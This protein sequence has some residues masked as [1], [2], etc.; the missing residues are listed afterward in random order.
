MYTSISDFIKDWEY[1]SEATLKMLNNITD[2]SLNKKENDKVRSLGRLSWHLIGS[3]SEMG[4]L[5]KMDVEKVEDRYTPNVSAKDIYDLYK[6]TADSL[7]YDIQKNWKDE[8][9]KEEVNMYGETWTKGT[10]LEVIIKHQIHHRGQMTVVMRLAGLKVPG[11]Y[12]P[13]YEEWAGMSMQPM[14]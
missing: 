2:E 13:A 5:G 4:A 3:I 6:K 12:G 9:L 11:V 8:D 10:L 1:E 7:K 14:E